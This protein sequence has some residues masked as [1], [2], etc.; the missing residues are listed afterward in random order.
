[1]TNGPVTASL[2]FTAVVPVKVLPVMMMCV[3]TPAWFGAG[4]PVIVGRI[5]SVAGLV[6]VPFAFVAE[7]DAVNAVSAIVNWK[8]VSVTE[9]ITI[10]FTP[11]FAVG[12]APVARK[13]EPFTV[14]GSPT[15]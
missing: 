12:F 7:T 8:L 2:N 5:F 13:L 1:M 15:W 6:D 14:T 10:A 11:S 9:P 4:S 3:P